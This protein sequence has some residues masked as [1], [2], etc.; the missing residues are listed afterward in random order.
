[1]IIEFDPEVID[2][3]KQHGIDYIFGDIT[4]SEI[5]EKANFKEARLVVSTSPNLEDNLTLLAELKLLKKRPRII[6]RAQTEKEAKVLY[7]EGAD[8]VLLTTF[9]SG[10][11]LGKTI[12][13]DPDMKILDILKERDLALMKGMHQAI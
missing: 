10:Q 2:Q 6:L 7:R 8:Y 4:D 3:L 13:I 12:A 1:M 11:Y 5:F 9:T